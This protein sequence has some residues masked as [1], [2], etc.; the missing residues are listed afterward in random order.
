MQLP[1]TLDYPIVA[2]GDIHGQREFLERL[3]AKLEQLAEWPGCSIV[4]LGDLMDRGP[5]VKGT[6]E[7]ILSL[8]RTRGNC[9]AVMGNHDLAPKRAAGLDGQ[10]PS[11]FWVRRYRIAYDHQMT[12]R[13]YLG[14][15]ANLDRWEEEL[16]ALH[17]AMPRDHRELL[18]ALPWVV[19][20][21]GHI[22]L[23]AGLSPELDQPAEKQVQALRERRWDWSLSPK[24][25]TRTSDLWQ[26]DYPVWIGADKRLSEFPLPLPGR[27]QVTGHVHIPEPDV[28]SVR[29]RIDTSGGRQEPLTACLLEHPTAPPR[30]IQSL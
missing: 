19:E 2:I 27:I 11:E 12:F 30:F 13:A 4:F 6:V 1:A 7:L 26:P 16:E 23:H 21:E 20:A 3:L 17:H 18:A 8:I 29:I 22:F 10:P 9:T 5:D 25:G 14:R 15:D 28:N 24:P